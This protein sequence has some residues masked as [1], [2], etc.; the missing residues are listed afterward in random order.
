MQ[1]LPELR[2][3]VGH[4]AGISQRDADRR[5]ANGCGSEGASPH[6]Q[7]VA[8][9]GLGTN[10]KLRAKTGV[11]RQTER[12]ALQSVAR[13]ILPNSRTAK[14]LRIRSYNSQVTVLKSLTHGTAHYSGLQTCGSVW[15]C[16][17]CAAKIA[18][19]RRLELQQAMSI[20]EG[21]GGAVQLL[22]LTTPH[23]RHSKLPDLIAAQAKALQSFIR[24]T[25]VKSIFKEMGYIGQV[26]AFEVTHGRKGTNNGWHPHYHF[27]Q[28]VQVHADRAQL[29]DWKTRLY[30]RWD[31]YCQKA[32][33]GSPSF[34]HGIDLQDGKQASNYVSKWGLE[35][36]M[37]KGH[38]KKAKAGGES[39][40]DL[41]R[42]V[43]ED[44]KDAQAAALF[45]EFATCFKGRRQLS[46]SNGLKALFTVEEKTD[47]EL[48]DESVDRSEF[49]GFLTTEQW[50]D[51]LKVK[52]RA[53]VLEIAAFAGWQGVQRYLSHIDG[54]HDDVWFPPGELEALR[55][56]LL[57]LET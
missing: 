46:W 6:P 40:F 12:F 35:D 4:G 54:A 47:E 17:I 53:V 27:L 3:A 9:S 28:F 38:I 8:A 15:A 44:K 25:T 14:C 1:R 21:R 10:A 55:R 11:E 2:S 57:K 43:L 32:G 19:R 34:Q 52:G 49:L 36:E 42:A 20:H 33:L 26:R 56:S 37:T 22:T 31:S 23:T 30:L 16:P 41:L 50:R 18:E 45:K 51:V 5:A 39:P 13:D 29:V 48:A 24:D 7:R